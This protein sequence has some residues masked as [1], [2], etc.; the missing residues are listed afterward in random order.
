MLLSEAEIREISE[1]H[2][3]NK[4]SGKIIPQFFIP[5]YPLDPD[6][7]DDVTPNFESNLKLKEPEVVVKVDTPEPNKKST[8]LDSETIHGNPLL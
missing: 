1:K 7:F 6:L 5:K 4:E 2:S 8:K 3:K